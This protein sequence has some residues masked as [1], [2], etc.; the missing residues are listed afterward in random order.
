MLVSVLYF[1]LPSPSLFLALVAIEARRLVH[2]F[3]RSSYLLEFL[4]HEF[5][6]DGRV[7]CDHD[8]LGFDIGDDF[9]DTVNLFQN[10]FHCI[11]AA[12]T[13][14]VRIYIGVVVV[15]VVVL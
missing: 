14:C 12:T 7:M 10:P 5:G 15:V 6:F 11:C 1:L 8:T 4:E 13:V 9:G 2:S 3:I